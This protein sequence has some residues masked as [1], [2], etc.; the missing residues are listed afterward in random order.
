MTQDV[1]VRR[2]GS[3]RPPAGTESVRDALLRAAATHFSRYGFAGA[4]I[5]AILADAGATAP[6]LYHHFGNKTGLY[7]AAATAAQEHVLGVFT[8]AVAD[9]DALADRT[10]ALLTAATSLRKEHPNVAKYLSVVQ[11]DISRHPELGEL[12]SY[13]TQFDRFWQSVAKGVEPVIATA[14]AV[15]ALVEGLLAVGGARAQTGDVAAAAAVLEG[16]TRNGIAAAPRRTRKAPA[17]TP[18][19]ARGVR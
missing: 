1:S 13:A 6:A 4:N 8:A 2:R 10:A 9:R 16:I 19:K 7:I 15:R 14:L 17:A 18:S 5:R 3:G 11:E 12:A